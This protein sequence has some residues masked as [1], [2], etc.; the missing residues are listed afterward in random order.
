MTG[1][2]STEPRDFE[3]L[4]RQLQTDLG[5]TTS[6]VQISY[7]SKAPSGLPEHSARVPSLCTFFSEG[8]SAGFFASQKAHE[9]CEV[10]AFVFGLPPAGELGAHLTQTVQW[11]EKIGYLA[12]GEAA[13]IP[14]NDSA[15]SFVAYGPLG[16][17]DLEPTV[18]LCFAPSKTAMW[19]L[20][21]H[22]RAWPERAALPLMGRPMCSIVPALNAGAPVAISTGCTGS[23]LYA[24]L[25]DGEM[26]LGVRGDALPKF[27]QA[28]HQIRAANELVLAEDT[29]RKAAAMAPA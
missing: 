6:P 21:A 7:L 26:V 3:G 5:M 18:V 28:L 2:P 1:S 24:G 14:R 29:Q 10:G 12:P 22:A 17:L 13:H 20:E 25:S 9:D 8:R 27:A 15:P 16:S 11:M 4:A 19:A 23:R